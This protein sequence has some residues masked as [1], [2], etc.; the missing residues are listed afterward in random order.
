MKRLLRGF[1]RSLQKIDSVARVMFIPVSEKGKRLFSQG[2]LRNG[3]A[4]LAAHM[5]VP[6]LISPQK[7][8]AGWEH[9]HWHGAELHQGYADDY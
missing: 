2:S 1:T 7:V 4:Q 6:E 9:A 8:V 3:M 5:P